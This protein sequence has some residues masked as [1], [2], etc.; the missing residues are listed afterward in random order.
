MQSS[1]ELMKRAKKSLIAPAHSPNCALFC[2]HPLSITIVNGRKPAW[3][4]IT[5]I[6][7]ENQW[8]SKL[9]HSISVVFG[10][11]FNQRVGGSSP[12]RFTKSFSP[13]TL[14]FHRTEFRIV[15]FRI[16]SASSK[17]KS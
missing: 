17:A 14:I 5:C 8:G 1:A 6:S 10:R 12:P 15:I 4:G 3:A 7:M 13:L 16:V 9:S 2:A 11:S